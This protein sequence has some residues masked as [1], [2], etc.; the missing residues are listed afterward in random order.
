MA[1]DIPQSVKALLQK[2][3]VTH[4]VEAKFNLTLICAW[5]F[6]RKRL[7]ICF[8]FQTLSPL[9]TTVYKEAF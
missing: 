2:Q 3:V 7:N 1:V 5:R 6:I 9:L 4:Y 8:K